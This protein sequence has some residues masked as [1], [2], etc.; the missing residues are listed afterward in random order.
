MDKLKY[1]LIFVGS[2]C[3]AA[4]GVFLLSYVLSDKTSDLFLAS[5]GILF[6]ID[7]EKM[8]VGESELLKSMIKNDAIFTPGQ[9][10]SEVSSFYERV[11]TIL[12][13]L[14]GVMGIVA[15]MYVK[16]V[17]EDIAL[18]VVRQAVDNRFNGHE[19]RDEISDKLSRF[20]D[21]KLEGAVADKMAGLEAL[22]GDLEQYTAKIRSEETHSSSNVTLRDLDFRIRE[23]E[24]YLASRDDEE[25]E[26]G[27]G[28]ILTS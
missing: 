26:D 2:V 9:L 11:I 23:V 28:S 1:T 15:Y 19:H 25:D 18:K 24:R 6:S 17:S 7:N 8:A 21:E 12:T 14:L 5:E 3:G 4:L 20:V 13:T 16:S 27:D 10:M 22:Q